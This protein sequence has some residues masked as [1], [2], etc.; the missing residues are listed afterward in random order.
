MRLPPPLEHLQ[1]R[2]AQ[3]WPERA[4][5]LKGASFALVGLVN[6]VVDYGVFL[7]GYYLV[8]LVLASRWMPVPAAKLL[9]IAASFVVNFSLSHFVV[10]RSRAGQAKRS[11]E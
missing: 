3:A 8:N 10:F 4:V 6:T 1:R 11:T 9:A 7:A 5:T 2:L